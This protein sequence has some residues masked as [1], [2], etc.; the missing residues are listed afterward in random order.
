[1]V[2]SKALIVHFVNKGGERNLSNSCG[3]AQLF[4]NLFELD[5]F[6]WNIHASVLPFA[7]IAESKTIVLICVL[8]TIEIT[9]PEAISD[10]GFF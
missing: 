5:L 6:F 3:N 2:K 9:F 1:V 8:M 4:K 10:T 7:L